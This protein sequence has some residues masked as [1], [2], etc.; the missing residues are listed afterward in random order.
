MKVLLR[1][2]VRSVITTPEVARKRPFRVGIG[3]MAGGM[4]A[5]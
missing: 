3:P 2:A 4:E 5:A 1:L